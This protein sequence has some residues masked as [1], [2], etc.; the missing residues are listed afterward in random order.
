MITTMNISA[1]YLWLPVRKEPPAARLF[2]LVD[3]D[4]IQEIDIHLGQKERYDFYAAVDMKEHLGKTLEIKG[5]PE[6]F[7]EGVFLRDGK[8][9]YSAPAP[10]LHFAPTTGWLNDP[11]G[12]VYC[13]GI[14]HLFYQYNPYGLVWGNMH[15]GHTW[16][17]DLIHWQEPEIALSPDDTGRMYSGSGLVDKEG[18]AGYGK[19]A[20]LFY[21]TA[22]EGKSFWSMRK[23]QNVTQR[24]A[25]SVDN[26]HTIVKTGRVVFSQGR[27]EDRD[28]KVFYHKESG[29]Y[30]MALY[31]DSREFMLLRSEN[32]L[33]WKE[34]QRMNFKGMWECP[35]LFELQV[36]GS[37][38]KKWVFWSADGYYVVGSFD[39]WYFRQES[40]VQTAYI[41]RL[42]YA[43]Q[44]YSNTEGRTVMVPWLRQGQPRGTHCGLMGLPMELDLVHD[45]QGYHIA[46][47]PV[48]EYQA[49]K[50]EPVPLTEGYQMNGK[51]AEVALIWPAGT[52]SG[53]IDLFVGDLQIRLDFA[54]E[55]LRVKDADSHYWKLDADLFT[56]RR[57]ELSFIVDNEVVEIRNGLGTLYGVVEAQEDVLEHAIRL[58]AP[59]KAEAT[60][61]S[62]L[63]YPV[64]V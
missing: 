15:W 12:L 26:G 57:L 25:Y 43:A 27:G 18:K 44:T 32:L 52:N 31:L 16:S 61:Q 30:I 35:D 14:Y 41:G 23:G 7:E 17:R 11:N 55:M 59:T 49:L 33:D 60:P 56:D 1:R 36:R 6:G 54:R 51:P 21:Y 62:A 64:R 4:I 24:L 58:E 19:N 22:T 48:R 13:D 39:G 38:E 28:P 42:P 8:P 20:L 40:E 10:K 5:L 47:T 45:V 9:E 3:G 53:Q 34:C 46:F 50:G 37:K 2:L 29:A 63:V